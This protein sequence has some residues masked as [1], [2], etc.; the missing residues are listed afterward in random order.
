MFKHAT[1]T[2]ATTKKRNRK[3]S[4]TR[5]TIRNIMYVVKHKSDINKFFGMNRHKKKKTQLKVTKSKHNNM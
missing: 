5:K 2:T 3:F 1:T 4:H